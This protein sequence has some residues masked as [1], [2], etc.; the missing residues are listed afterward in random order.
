MRACHSLQ[1]RLNFFARAALPNQTPGDERE[2]MAVSTE[3]SSICFRAFSGVH[4][5]NLTKVEPVT[6]WSANAFT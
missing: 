4:F 1:R 6:P 2:V 3:L 5:G